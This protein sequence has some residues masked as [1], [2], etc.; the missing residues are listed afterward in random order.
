MPRNMI[1]KVKT[2]DKDKIVDSLV[3]GENLF[4]VKEQTGGWYYIS[5]QKPYK[6]EDS[7]ATF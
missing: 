3:R 7:F 5:N 2:V 4:S 1:I 6:P